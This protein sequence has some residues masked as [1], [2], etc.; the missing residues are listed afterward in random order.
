MARCKR[1]ANALSPNGRAGRAGQRPG[2][3]RPIGPSPRPR[4]GNPSQQPA[5]RTDRNSKSEGNSKGWQRIAAAAG[6]LFHAPPSSLPLLCFFPQSHATGN[7]ELGERQGW[8]NW[9]NRTR[10]FSIKAKET[11]YLLTKFANRHGLV[12]GA[13]RRGAPSG[14]QP[15]KRGRSLYQIPD[16]PGRRPVGPDADP[17]HLGGLQKSRWIVKRAR[18]MI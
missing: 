9:N 3:R 5:F 7:C 10:F 11:P 15:P 16:A 2:G 1:T 4:R 13:L 6:C 8:T 14:K 17:G 18:R 12:A